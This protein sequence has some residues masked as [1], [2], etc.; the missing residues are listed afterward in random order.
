M[1][2]PNMPFIE[3][4][5]SM[6]CLEASELISLR[7]D[8]SLSAEQEQALQAHLL[9]CHVCQ[10]EWRMMQRVTALFDKV[11]PMLPPPLMKERI[12]IRI[13]Q[14]DSRL[15]GWRR[16][17]LL[18]LGTITALTLCSILFI[19]LF[20]LVASALNGPFVIR[21]AV[22]AVTHIVAIVTTVFGASALCVRALL[23]SP[24][25]LILVG[26]LILAG[27]LLLG[28]T[29]LVTRPYRA[30]AEQQGPR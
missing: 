11:S 1:N 15:A 2:C 5:Q 25:W 26:Y 3:R 4:S 23:A 13:R 19:G 16:G 28:W 12:M 24:N 27:A 8:G 10:D 14:R 29:S 22:E 6:Q 21:T 7:L 18:S 17:I 9:D 30:I 20:A